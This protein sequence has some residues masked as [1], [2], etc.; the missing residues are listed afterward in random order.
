MLGFFGFGFLHPLHSQFL[1][2][3]AGGFLAFAGSPRYVIAIQHLLLETS[4]RDAIRAI[5]LYRNRTDLRDS[6][7]DG[8][9]S[10]T[11]IFLSLENCS[12]GSG[13]LLLE[14]E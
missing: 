6:L 8:V 5:R 2:G 7:E 14:K 12:T 3:R 13:Y 4:K 11:A 9:Q 10:N 1:E